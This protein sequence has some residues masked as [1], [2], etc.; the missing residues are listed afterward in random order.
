MPRQG[1]D[2]ATTV[3]SSPLPHV[4]AKQRA[5]VEELAQKATIRPD[6][7]RLPPAVSIVVVNSLET[8]VEERRRWAPA[9]R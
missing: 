1:R 5:R 2:R 6:T 8:L 4:Y 7:F 3:A 9:H